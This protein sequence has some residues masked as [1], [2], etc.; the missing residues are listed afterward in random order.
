MGMEIPRAIHTLFHLPFIDYI[1][2]SVFLNI[3]TVSRTSYYRG[4]KCATPK[5][6]WHADYFRLKAIKAQK[7][8]EE[9]L[10]FPV[11]A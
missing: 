9:N 1:K 4:A 3:W 11:T 2:P 8:Q 7:T 10:T 6:L 5:S